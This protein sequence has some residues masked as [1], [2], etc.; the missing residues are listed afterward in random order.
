MNI[1]VKPIIAH[2]TIRKGGWMLTRSGKRFYPCDPHPD[3]ID[4]EDIA[5]GLSAQ[6][7]FAGQT[8]TLLTVAEHSV[9]CSRYAEPEFKLEALLHDAVE[10]YIGDIPSPAKI[11]LPDFGAMEYAIW[12]EAI[13]VKYDLPTTM[14]AE[15]HLV[16]QRMLVTEAAQIMFPA[17][18]GMTWWTDAHWPPPYKHHRVSGWAPRIAEVKFLK[19]FCMLMALPINAYRAPQKSNVYGR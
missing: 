7:R 16:D 18:D 3:D 9:W 19:E 15:V 4:I 13:A 6:Y 8:G 2:A 11:A 1:A 5:V 14:S 17:N 12:A 10:A